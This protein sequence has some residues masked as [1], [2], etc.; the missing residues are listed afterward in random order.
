MN[1]DAVQGA[2]G[3]LFETIG[4]FNL[5]G[6]WVFSPNYLQ[7][8][9]MV[10]C[11]FLLI[12]TFG[13]LRHRYNHWTVKGIFPGIALGFLLALLVEAALLVGG[14]TIITEV[15]G[16]KNAPKPISNVL[17]ASRSHLVDVLG[18]TVPESKADQKPTVDAIMQSIENLTD[19]EVDSLKTLI[20]PRE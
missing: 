9:L 16:W 18:V 13:M 14:R 6:G 1:L 10:L 4:D 17:D 20:C 8:G 12:L 2:P 15:L 7:A 3:K 11:V 5:P 19:S